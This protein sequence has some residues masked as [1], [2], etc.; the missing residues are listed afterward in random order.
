MAKIAPVVEPGFLS[1][2]WGVR[3]YVYSLAKVLERHGWAVD[4]VFPEAAPSGEL[5]WYKLHLRDSSLFSAAGP[6]AGA[7]TAT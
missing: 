2:H 7:P 4:F 1:H 3:V 6:S 5:R